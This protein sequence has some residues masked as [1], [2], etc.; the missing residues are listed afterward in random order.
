VTLVKSNEFFERCENIAHISTLEDY[1]KVNKTDFD[2]YNAEHGA[3]LEIIK[4]NDRMNG[5]VDCYG[6]RCIMTVLDDLDF[7]DIV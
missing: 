1:P 7:G 4:E 2:A 6:S 3:Q 5:N